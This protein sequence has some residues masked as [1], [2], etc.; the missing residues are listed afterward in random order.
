[1]EPLVQEEYTNVKPVQIHSYHEVAKKGA[2]S[3]SDLK[4]VEPKKWKKVR[5]KNLFG[6]KVGV[7]LSVLVLPKIFPIY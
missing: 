1:M 3:M 7:V 6:P 2:Y 5:T 4:L